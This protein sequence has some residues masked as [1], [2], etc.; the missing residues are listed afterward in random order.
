MSSI[1]DVYKRQEHG[2][3]EGPGRIARA[4]R[5]PQCRPDVAV[6]AVEGDLWQP[7]GRGLLSL[8]L[9]GLGHLHHRCQVLAV[10]MGLGNRCLLY[11]SRCV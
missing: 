10:G 6:V 7:V 4:M 8:F 3:G 9:G 1:I 11:T 5:V 2:Y